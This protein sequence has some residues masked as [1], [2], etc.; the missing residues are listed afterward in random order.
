MGSGEGDEGVGFFRGQE[1]VKEEN[2]KVKKEDSNK[3]RQE[4]QDTSRGK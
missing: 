4:F 1:G 2:C 3:K